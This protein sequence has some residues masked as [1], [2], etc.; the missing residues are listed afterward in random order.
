MRIKKAPGIVP[1]IKDFHV[2][3][4]EILKG[5]KRKLID[6][7]LVESENVIAKIE[8]EIDRSINSDYP[9]NVE[10]E[11]KQLL[12]RNKHVEKIFEQCL[13][14][15]WKKLTNHVDYGYF[16]PKDVS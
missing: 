14:K 15:K 12:D 9:D 2:K 8:L 13:K 6:F 5:T 11:A 7:V 4:N 3:W 1:V 10:D 16:K